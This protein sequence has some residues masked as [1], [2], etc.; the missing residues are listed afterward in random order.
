MARCLRLDPRERF[1]SA[2]EVLEALNAASGQTR[3]IAITRRV[4]VTAM[5]GAAAELAGTIY[6]TR[7]RWR[8]SYPPESLIVLPFRDGGNNQDAILLADGLTDGLI[9]ALSR[10]QSLRVIAHGSAFHYKGRT[11]DGKT[12]HS[13]LNVTRVLSGKVVETQ[14]D[15][16]RIALEL[17]T[18]PEGRRIWSKEY[19][20]PVS[21]ILALQHQ[22]A[23][24]LALL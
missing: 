18:A 22:I 13:E 3:R 6:A 15:Q 5:A 17:A 21:A 14:L 4:S 20:G 12:L 24:D 8:G 16:L 9:D 7:G 10:H 19:A 11:V 1:A 23:A 2:S